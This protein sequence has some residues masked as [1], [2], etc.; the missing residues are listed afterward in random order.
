M[1]DRVLVMDYAPG[2][3]VLQRHPRSSY[4]SLET[5]VTYVK[6]VAAALQNLI[7]NFSGIALWSRSHKRFRS[8]S[9]DFHPCMVNTDIT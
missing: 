8:L 1:I 5:T 3:T 7:Q 9:T 6:Q 4:L 2:G